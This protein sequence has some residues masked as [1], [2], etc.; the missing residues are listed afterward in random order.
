MSDMKKFT[1]EVEMQE[2]WIPHFLSMLHYMQ[3]LGGMGASRTVSFYADGDRDFRPMFKPNVEYEE[4]KP[5]IDDHG[6][7]MYDA[8]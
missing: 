2:R 3:V 1:I 6:N 4:Q 7:R 5:V 8:G